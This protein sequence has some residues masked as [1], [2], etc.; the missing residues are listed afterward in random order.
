[1]TSTEAD[2][3]IL[4]ESFG[5]SYSSGKMESTESTSGEFRVTTVLEQGYG[6]S[7]GGQLMERKGP[8]VWCVFV[9]S[10][11]SSVVVAIAVGCL[12]ALLY[13]ILRELRVERVI[14][15]DGTEERMLGFWS[16]LILSVIVGCIIS[17]F[18]WILTYLDSDQ[19]GMVSLTHTHF[20][21]LF[22]PSFHLDYGAAVLNGAMALLTIIWSL[23]WP[24]LCRC[25]S[26]CRHAYTSVQ[27]QWCLCPFFNVINE[28]CHSVSIG[29]PDLQ[30]R[31][32]VSYGL[33]CKGL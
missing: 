18:S 12:C 23:I 28:D 26:M 25:K 33:E 15:P 14:G 1:M 11:L 13:P 3:G 4:T 8:R 2:R 9:L 17:F 6:R 22:G 29:P 10:V 7:T 32:S 5:R 19:P 21:D 24:T 31:R 20:R 27:W 30:L 16:I